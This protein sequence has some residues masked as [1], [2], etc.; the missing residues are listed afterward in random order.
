MYQ[1]L[2]D[3]TRAVEK[4]NPSIEEFD[5][6]VFT[7]KYIAGDVGEKYLNDLQT[8]RSDTAKEA[9]RGNDD[10]VIDLHNTA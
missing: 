9:R 1:D 10:D 4:G 8:S 7:G 3:L 5:A 2:K 6:S